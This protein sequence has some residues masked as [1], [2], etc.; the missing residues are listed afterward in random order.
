MHRRSLDLNQYL[1][2]ARHWHWVVFYH[3]EAIKAKRVEHEGAHRCRDIVGG[4]VIVL[5]WGAVAV[6]YSA[7]CKL[8]RVSEL[9]SRRSMR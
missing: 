1:P 2:R 8:L 3:T 9:E 5:G 4:H 6:N 7:R